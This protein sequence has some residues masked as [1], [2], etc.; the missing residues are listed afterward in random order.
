M[1]KARIVLHRLGR[2]AQGPLDSA[3]TG[4]DGRFR[5]WYRPDSQSV[6]LLSARHAGIEHF[7]E[8]IVAGSAPRTDVMVVVSDTSS[9]APVT[10]AGRFLLVSAPAGDSIRTVID[11]LV[12]ENASGATRVQGDSLS[13]TWTLGRVPAVRARIEDGT[14]FSPEAIAFRNDS[15]FLYAPV[16]PGRRQ[17]VVAYEMPLDAAELR[18]PVEVPADTV[19]VL[20]EEPALRIGAPGLRETRPA[21]IEQRAVRQWTGSA[22]AGDVIT[23]EFDRPVAN[24]RW[25]LVALVS[26]TAAA[27]V[28]GLVG[29]WQW[30]GASRPSRLSR[31]SRPARP[32]RPSRPARFPVDDLVDQVARLD[33]AYR[34]RRSEVSPEDWTDYESRRRALVARLTTALAERGRPA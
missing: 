28:L 22:R 24:P 16:S 6:Y 26:L 7:S 20:A 13:P 25:A 1:P 21:Q 32:S 3:R 34:G 12:L 27:L 15:L 33:L 17:I 2:Q 9:T 18:I 5:F 10:L 31:P 4:L 30:G 23:L 19:T 8:P 29:W 14:E 11:V